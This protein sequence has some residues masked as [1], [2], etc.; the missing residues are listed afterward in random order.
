MFKITLIACG[1][2]MPSWVDEAVK[3]YVKRLREYVNLSIIEIPLLKRT[4]SGDLTRILEK[5]S[6]LIID[7]IPNAARVIAMEIEGESFSSEKLATKFEM[8][9]QVNSHI[10]FLIGG[11]EGLSANTL[12]R[13][14]ERWSLSSLTLPHPMVRII[15]FE[16]IY[17]AWSIINNHPYHK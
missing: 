15:L 9:T 17:R 13:C 14:D 6:A 3:E 4:K 5:E 11:P 2:K 8:I 10:C 16:A 12:A 7:A 1:N